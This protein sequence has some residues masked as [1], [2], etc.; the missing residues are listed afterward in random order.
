[1]A[2]LKNKCFKTLHI[3]YQYKEDDVSEHTSYI[4]QS[5]SMGKLIYIN[6]FYF[7]FNFSNY[8]KF[9]FRHMQHFILL[10]PFRPRHI[11][12]K[13]RNRKRPQFLH[14][15]HKLDFRQANDKAGDDI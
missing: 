2:K 10:L 14:R 7:Y 1:M 12:P 9:Q 15:K 6:D 5:S 11:Q 13:R 8:S 4:N 3:P